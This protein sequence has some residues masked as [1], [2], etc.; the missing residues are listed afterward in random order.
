MGKTPKV[1]PAPPAVPATLDRAQIS[2]G[3]TAVRPQIEACGTAHPAGGIMKVH[4][5]VAPA[6]TVSSAQITKGLDPDLDACVQKVLLAAQFAKTAQG[7][8]FTYP[9]VFS[10]AVTAPA[11]CDATALK[12]K[13]MENVNRGQHAAALAQF[14]A[15]LRCKNDPLVVALAFMSACNSLNTAKAT[16]YYGKLS[17]SDQQKYRPICVRNHV[18]VT[19]ATNVPCDADALK[20][21]ALEL[22]NASKHAEALAKLEQSLQCKADSYVTSLAFIEAC[23]AQ[24]SPKAKLYYTKLTSAQQQKYAV[25]CTRNKTAYQDSGSAAT[26][27]DADALK[28][29][30]MELVNQG[31]FQPALD[32]FEQSLA[33]KQDAYVVALAFMA[34]CNAS[35]EAK[36]RAYYKA[37][38]VDQRSKYKVMCDRNNVAYEDEDPNGPKGYLEIASAPAAKIEIDGADTGLTTPIKGHALALSPGKHRVTFI[39]GDD[40]FTYFAVIKSGATEKMT[41]DLR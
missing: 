3:V 18:D 13:G 24:D 19:G 16:A 10:A 5:E 39:I 23:N 28:D 20:D 31:Q 9:F 40:R 35:N 32:R 29:R 41:K 14:E 15:S 27:C 12:D 34:S 7:G 1:Q 22:I 26:A 36:A 2:A 11:N 38:G 4:V 8:T 25:M 30:G 17:N 33:C 6:G 37:L 21:R